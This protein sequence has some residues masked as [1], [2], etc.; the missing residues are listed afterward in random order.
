MTTSGPKRRSTWVAALL[1]LLQPGLGQ[2]YC[3]RWRAAGLFYGL[4]IIWLLAAIAGL[5]AS[6]PLWFATG[7]LLA[8]SVVLV[9]P[10]AIVEAALGARRMQEFHPVWYARWYVCLFVFVVM[11]VGTVLYSEMLKARV[12]AF[13]IPATSMVPA[14]RVDDYVLVQRTPAGGSV[15]RPCDVVVFRKPGLARE[16]EVDYVKRAIALPGDRVGYVGGRLR[17][18]GKFVAREQVGSDAEGTTYRETLPSGC[19]YLI[20]ER[21]DDGP[22]DNTGESTVPPD[23]FYA[24]GDNRD[25]SMD[26]RVL[27]FGPIPF[28]NYRG[29]VVLIYW[30]K[31]WSR[32]GTIF[33]SESLH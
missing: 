13:H 8:A 19:S 2:L 1:S 31:D 32:I 20:R 14:L 6:S 5:S 29:R 12:S 7:W 4:S 16:A 25:D 28:N 10:V 27:S 22:L 15:I 11:A 24:L 33:H 21:Y 9:L 30:S 18:N 23:S 26:S 17:L 3:G